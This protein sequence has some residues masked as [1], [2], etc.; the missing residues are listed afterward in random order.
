VNL[1][2]KYSALLLFCLLFIAGSPLYAQPQDNDSK[3]GAH[4]FSKGEFE[5]AEIYYEKVYKKYDA[6]LYFSR[7]Y[8]C[9]FYQQKYEECEKLVEKRIKKDPYTIENHFMLAAVYEE[10]DRVPEAELL[11][12]NLIEELE[13]I[14]TRVDA[15][16]EAFQNR[17]MYEYA[18]ETYL[19][20]RKIL[21]KGYG[22]QLELAA[23][24]SILNRPADMIAEYLNLLDYSP[25]YIKTVQSYLSR[26][27][28]FD[29]DFERVEMLRE[30]I[31]LKVQKNPDQ[32]VYN[33]MFIW[34]YLQKK[35]FAG[36]VIQVKALDKKK[37]E[38]GRRVIEIA[39]VCQANQAF[40]EAIKA[41]D[42]VIGLGESNPYYYMA[43]ER[44]LAVEFE[45]LT[46]KSSYTKEEIQTIA[47]GFEKALSTMGKSKKSL[48]TMT[49]LARIYA[50]YL[51]ETDKAMA[52]VNEA[53]AL[54][55]TRHELAVLKLL[56]GDIYVVANDIWEASLLYMQVE[57]EFSE[58]IIG[59]EAKF[60]NAKVFYYDGEF[61]YAKAQL[62]VLKAST[63]KLIANNAMQLSLLLQDNLG[64]DTTTAPVQ[65]YAN[66][67]LLLAQNKFDEAI[68]MLDS[69]EKR[70]PF[71]SMVDEVLFKKAEI[72]E[73]LQKWDL[74][75][76]FY[77]EVL[78]SYSHDILGDD[79][80]FRLAKIYDDRL[81]NPQKAAEFYKKILFDFSGSLYTADARERYREII[82]HFN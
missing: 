49:Q 32:T 12:K 38:F 42:Y 56:K 27:I 65:M 70:Y 33:E 82:A 78:E 22:F 63:S 76:E 52:L 66:A 79:A 6:Q 54:P 13:P 60:K 69:L 9:L 46:R 19:R 67:D 72:Y 62:D 47:L 81:N 74:A 80:A 34:Y 39:D 8:Y 16:G 35:E 73:G 51:D 64:V 58:D 18:L 25:T 31:L 77:T 45:Q 71:H 53:L 40:L 1:W 57:K 7:Y 55:L 50:F 48:G 24:Y 30:E 5:K 2:N 44:K 23:I 37:N 17:A 11:Y 10:T 29:T 41:Y 3:L 26:A 36:A 59:H 43:T 28:D 15:L 75:I 14:Q 68:A 20:G 21:K 61:D 4:Y